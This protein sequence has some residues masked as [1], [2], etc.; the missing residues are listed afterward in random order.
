MES[1]A[2]LRQLSHA[3]KDELILLLWSQVQTLTTQNALMQTQIAQLQG[4][5]ALN[6]KNSSKP[7]SSDGLNKPQPK[8]LRPLGQRPS[9]GQPGHPGKTLSKVADPEVVVTH[10]PAAHCEGC[11]RPLSETTVVE[12]RQV[13]DLP[14]LSFKVTEHQLLQ[15]VCV[16]GKP[17]RG[18]FPQQVTASVQY[19]PA[20][21][22][23]MVHLTHHHMMPVQRTADLMGDLF[24]MSVSSATVLKACEEG[25]ECLQPIVQA[26]AQALQTASIVN[27]D[28]SGLR[29]NKTLHWLHVAANET[30]TWLG[31][32]P[33]RGKEAF[34]ALGILSDFNGTLIHDGWK[35]YRALNCQHG[36]CN[37]HHLRE[38]TYVHEEQGQAWAG[39]MIA[40]LQH[41][42]AQPREFGHP[43]YLPRVEHLRYVYPEILAQGDAANP[44]AHASGK[45][46]RT[47]QSK[48][49]NLLLRL[50]EQADDV[51]RFMTDPGVPFTNNLAEQAVRMP[52][53][54]QKISGCFRTH[55][56]AE[57]FCIL[58]S[59]LATLHKQGAQ[60]FD[61]LIKTFQGAP[62]QPRFA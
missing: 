26:I 19:G 28:E 20:A 16:C 3:Q 55:Q 48:A 15:A 21:L 8:S 37:A 38:L 59:Y 25:K 14:V 57:T 47:A 46:G 13:F 17:H 29:V 1:L 9:G 60:L 31:C 45:R 41:A 2:D 11:Q 4:R 52:K 40:L 32:H 5:L 24:G 6:S 30:L 53:V 36:L 34:A 7:P 10:A 62:P 33:K 35:P 43:D 54:K 51:W 18:Q 56:G 49:T 39:D 27:A 44:Q 23:A 12:T 50:R 42:N 22:A 61:A 58:R